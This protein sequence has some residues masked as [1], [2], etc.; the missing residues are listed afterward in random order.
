MSFSEVEQ[1]VPLKDSDLFLHS[2]ILKPQ[3]EKFRDN[4]E[5]N[6]RHREFDGLIK[7]NHRVS[8]SLISFLIAKLQIYEANDLFP[9]LKTGNLTAMLDSL[10]RVEQ[11][12]NQV[13]EIT[14]TKVRAFEI[15]SSIFCLDR[16][17][18]NQFGESQP[19]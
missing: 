15:F 19:N 2:S 11:R 17:F 6:Q 16:A 18:T 7:R 1:G 14:F 8:L 13:N 12:L 3:I 9:H 4:F 10:K 5:R